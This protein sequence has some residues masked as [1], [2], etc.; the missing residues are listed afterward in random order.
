M[1]FCTDASLNL[2]PMSLFASNT[3]F[4]ALAHAFRFAS[5]PVKCPTSVSTKDTYEGVVRLPKLLAM[6]STWTKTNGQVSVSSTSSLS[7]F[8]FEYGTYTHHAILDDTDARIGR[9]QVDA[10]GLFEHDSNGSPGNENGSPHKVRTQT[11]VV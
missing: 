6:I 11:R 4:A 8:F 1:S 2:H 7:A 5:S 3:V 10:N 9:A